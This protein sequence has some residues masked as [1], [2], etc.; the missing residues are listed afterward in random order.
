M[1]NLSGLKLYIICINPLFSSPIRLEVG[2][3]TS[4]KTKYV[5]GSPL[6]VSNKRIVNPGVFLSIK[7]M[8]KHEAFFS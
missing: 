5:T 6:Y 1:V 3:L 4:S 2:I 7:T 8:D